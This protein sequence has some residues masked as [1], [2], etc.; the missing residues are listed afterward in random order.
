MGEEVNMQ[1]GMIIDYSSLSL[2]RDCGSLRGEAWQRTGNGGQIYWL[3][4][5]L[6]QLGGPSTDGAA[7]YEAA[8]P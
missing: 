8:L 4:T 7:R 5:D 2:R 1:M 3:D 6:A